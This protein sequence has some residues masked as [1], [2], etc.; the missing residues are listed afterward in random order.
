[1]MKLGLVSQHMIEGDRSARFPQPRCPP[2]YSED[3]Y[4]YWPPICVQDRWAHLWSTSDFIDMILC[5]LF[6]IMLLLADGLM[7]SMITSIGEAALTHK[8][9]SIEQLYR[10][11]VVVKHP[12]RI[13]V[14]VAA[15]LR[16]GWFSASLVIQFSRSMNNTYIL[17][18]VLSSILFHFADGPVTIYVSLLTTLLTSSGLI[19]WLIY[20]KRQAEP[21]TTDTTQCK[22]GES[23]RTVIKATVAPIFLGFVHIGVFAGIQF[24]PVGLNAAWLS[25]TVRCVLAR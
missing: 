14:Q 1:M 15:A 6:H 4:I 22:Y 9:L 24:S 17:P 20:E 19:A 13:A 16:L 23:F 11:F 8:C 2:G 5:V 12:W 7:V 25:F 10:C 21:S 3:N 18:T